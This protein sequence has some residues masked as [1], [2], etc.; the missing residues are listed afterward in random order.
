SFSE[1]LENGMKNFVIDLADLQHINSSGLGVLITLLTKARK[2]G[3]EVTL[4]N[5][6]TYINNLLLITKLNTIFQIHPTKEKA[7]SIYKDV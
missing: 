6:S 3:G 1:Q 2:V 5:P 4:S 7:I